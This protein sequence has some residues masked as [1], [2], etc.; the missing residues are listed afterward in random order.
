M[1]KK[2]LRFL[3]LIFGW[4]LVL[5]S[6]YMFFLTLGNQLDIFLAYNLSM[7]FFGLL[8]LY[9]LYKYK[10]EKVYLGSGLIFGY[11]FVLLILALFG[12]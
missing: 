12:F 9:Y 8:G 7:L 1:N 10:Q 3:S 4:W 11:I 5:S 2:F 6:I